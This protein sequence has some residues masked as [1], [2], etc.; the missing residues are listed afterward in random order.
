ML[1]KKF[2]FVVIFLSS[3][4]NLT[5]NSYSFGF[6]RYNSGA[7]AAA[8]AGAFEA[9]NNDAAAMFFNP[10]TI[11]TVD[12]K[13]FSATFL[14]H[15]LD[16]NS[17]NV[18]YVKS[19]NDVG[20]FAL[21]AVYSNY[22]SFNAADNIGNITGTFGAN[23]FAFSVNYGNELDTNLYYGIAMKYIF[24]NIDQYNS[25]ALAF[26]IGLLYNLADKRTSLAA[27]L[28]NA[29]FQLYSYDGVTESLPLDIRLGVN[30]RLAGLPLLIALSFHHLGDRTD[31]FFD[32]FLNFSIGGEFHI[33]KY[34]NIRLG[35]DNYIRRYT[36]PG[37]EKKLSGFAGGVGIK[38]KYFN[39]DYALSQVGS[40]NLLNRFSIY[41]E[42]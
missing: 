35:Y 24:S 28:L 37:S 41:L 38:T 19:Y 9:V 34:V 7:R 32:R 30:H 25:S 31:V 5:A 6:L 13:R 12:I 22:G 27:S 42:F 40:S 2:V 29:G 11:N 8:M 18:T 14:K 23:D 16:I 21:S 17:G 20:T 1:I 3:A 39:F 4:Y 10:A 33:G 36:T 15:T 26:D